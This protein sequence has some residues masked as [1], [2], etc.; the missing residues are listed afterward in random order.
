MELQIPRNN[1]EHHTEDLGSSKLILRR[2]Q[3]FILTI[4]FSRPFQPQKD[5][6]TFV[7]ETGELTLPSGSSGS[8]KTESL[9]GG[10]ALATSL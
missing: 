8:L 6:L 4:V 3:I 9:P 5:H 2:G 1:K 7:A 10:G